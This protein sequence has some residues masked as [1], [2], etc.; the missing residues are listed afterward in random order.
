MPVPRIERFGNATLHLGDCRELIGTLP[1]VGGVVTDP[2]YGIEE[3]VGGYSRSGATILNDRTLDCCFQALSLIAQRMVD[4]RMAA[5]YSARISDKFFGFVNQDVALSG[6]Y[7]DEIIW[8]KKAPGMGA[9]VRYQHENVALFEFGK[10]PRSAGDVMSVQ[11]VMR[12]PKFH[13]HQKPIALLHTLINV[14]GGQTILDPFMG[15]G[16][17]GVAAL[18]MGK[19]FIGIELDPRHFDTACRRIEEASKQGAGLF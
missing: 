1:Q 3:L 14:V 19:A 13:P 5:F 9:G 12:E 8:D 16:S 11:P 6:H 7:V 10:P 15:S 2:P 17:T 18:A 4:F